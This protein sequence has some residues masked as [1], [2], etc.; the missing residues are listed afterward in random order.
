[1]ANLKPAVCYLR[2]PTLTSLINFK[3]VV[4]LRLGHNKWTNLQPIFFQLKKPAPEPT[5]DGPWIWNM[6]RIDI[7]NSFGVILVTLKLLSLLNL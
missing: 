2:S 7:R 5:A 6:D 4:P 1:M 3:S